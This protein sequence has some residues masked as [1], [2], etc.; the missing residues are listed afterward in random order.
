MPCPWRI[1]SA[2]SWSTV[3]SSNWI[4][5]TVGAV[6]AVAGAAV[7]TA[8][9]ADAARAPMVA[10]ASATLPR[11]RGCR[12]SVWVSLAMGSPSVCGPPGRF[13]SVPTGGLPS[14]RQRARGGQVHGRLDRRERLDVVLELRGAVD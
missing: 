3:P 8:A 5:T 11:D 12:G 7:R 14:E 13:P 10:I 6:A 4:V 1:G 9:D 2:A